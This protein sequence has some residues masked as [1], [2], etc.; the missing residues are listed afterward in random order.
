[1]E[2]SSDAIP[3]SMVPTQRMLQMS[4]RMSEIPGAGTIGVPLAPASDEAQS[5]WGGRELKGLPCE[6]LLTVKK[7]M[8]Q[9]NR[10]S[11]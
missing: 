7:C 9:L 3:V 6:C 1:M 2:S 10:V 4:Y 11:I 5:V 8:M